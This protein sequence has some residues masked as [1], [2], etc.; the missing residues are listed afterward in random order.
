MIITLYFFFI[1]A[2]FS[3]PSFHLTQF[4]LLLFFLSN[5]RRAVHT[6][7]PV[8]CS[9]YRAENEE[10][11]ARVPP[12]LFLSIFSGLIVCREREIISFFWYVPLTR[13]FFFICLCASY[14]KNWA[15]K[16]RR[17]R[18]DF[19]LITLCCV[20]HTQCYFSIYLNVVAI[21]SKIRCCPREYFSTKLS[22]WY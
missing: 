2:R 6:L 10:I 18:A 1:Q 9:K 16:K 13:E 7:T 12:Y 5:L 4:S 3:L 14:S 17:K 19:F 21:W 20:C 15:S 11:P 22:E 8:D